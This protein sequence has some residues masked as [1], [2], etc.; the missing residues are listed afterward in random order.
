MEYSL[1]NVG[2]DIN[3]ASHQ[4]KLLMGLLGPLDLPFECF[5]DSDIIQSMCFLKG[6]KRHVLDLS[7][8][9]VSKYACPTA[10]SSAW[11]ILLS[12]C[13]PAEF[14]NL[15]TSDQ[16]CCCPEM[17]AS[18]I[19]ASRN[20]AISHLW[21]PRFFKGFCRCHCADFSAAATTFSGV[22]G[23][24]GE[25]VKLGLQKIVQANAKRIKGFFIQQIFFVGAYLS[26]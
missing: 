23:F 3:K 25:A 17:R 19:I 14:P 13:H 15:I 24:A 9:N 22:A 7:A 26:S 18:S 11:Y 16:Y 20:G 21:I 1:A 6:F 8:M 10:W 5:F 2:G 4:S 12:G